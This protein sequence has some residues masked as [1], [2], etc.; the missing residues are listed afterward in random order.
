MWNPSTFDCQ[1]DKSCD[2]PK[3]LHYMNC[4]CR[5]KLSDMLVEKCNE[6][7]D[8]KEMTYDV[9]LYDFGLNKKVCKS[10][11]LYAILLILTWILIISGTYITVIPLYKNK[12]YQC[13]IAPTTQQLSYIYVQGGLILLK[14]FLHSI[15]ASEDLYDCNKV[16]P[17][18]KQNYH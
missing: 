4:K 7:I 16:I 17:Y 2:V 5:G 13:S 6:A 18:I 12:L 3:Y 9:T 15:Y 10:C 14:N 1:C 11:M 8:G